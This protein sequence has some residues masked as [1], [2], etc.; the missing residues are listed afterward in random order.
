MK[1]N[2]KATNIV[3]TPE[4]QE[5]LDKKLQMIERIA[6]AKNLFCEVELGKT[7]NHHNQGDIMRA[8]INCTMDGKYFR[9][10]SEQDSLHAAIDLAKDEILEEIKAF[11]T[12]RTTLVRRGGAMM[13]NIIKGIYNPFKKS[14]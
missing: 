10:V 2:I 6:S 13:K 11:K 9:S 4:T 1:T 7:T 12:K 3:I 5:Y 14:R 8:E